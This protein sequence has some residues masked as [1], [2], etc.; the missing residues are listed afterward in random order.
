M[1]KV[2]RRTGCA[3]AVASRKC[4]K[5]RNACFG[6]HDRISGSCV[7]NASFQFVSLR[8]RNACVRNAGETLLKSVFPKCPAACPTRV[9]PPGLGHACFRHTTETRA[10]T[11]ISPRVS[12][13][14]GTQARKRGQNLPTMSQPQLCVAASH[15]RIGEVA[16]CTP[17][18]TDACTDSG[19]GRTHALMHALMHAR[20]HRLKGWAHAH[21]HARTH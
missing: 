5:V 12:A 9:F 2:R 16:Q 6:K 17:L 1:R 19:A 7:R 21:T 11:R 15:A 4:E 8:F 14:R 20:M 18:L 13:T 3:A 10:E